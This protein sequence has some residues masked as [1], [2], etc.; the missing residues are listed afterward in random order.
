MLL[1]VQ[2]KTDK[3]DEKNENFYKEVAFISK[4]QVDIYNFKNYT[5]KSHNPVQ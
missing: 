5:I 2:V 3:I 4:P 1:R